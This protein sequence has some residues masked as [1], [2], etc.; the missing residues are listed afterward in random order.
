M[1]PSSAELYGALSGGGRGGQ[2]YTCGL[3]QHLTPSAPFIPR[4]GGRCHVIR[5]LRNTSRTTQSR[6]RYYLS[7][8]SL[9]IRWI[10]RIFFPRETGGIAR[11]V[12]GGGTRARAGSG[13]R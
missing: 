9:A 12:L 10:K 11:R 3:M 13:P 8:A 5:I 1:R 4:D 2:V 7:A 6:R